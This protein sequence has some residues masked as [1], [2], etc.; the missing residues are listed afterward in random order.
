MSDKPLMP[1][2]INAVLLTEHR[3]G[4]CRAIVVEA[5]ENQRAFLCGAAVVPRGDGAPG[6]WCRF[7]RA[8][9]VEPWPPRPI[10]VIKKPVVT[11]AKATVNRPKPPA[12]RPAEVDTT[13]FILLTDA[14]KTLGRPTATLHTW[15]QTGRIAR[16]KI[17]GRSFFRISDVEQ[18]AANKAKPSITVS[19]GMGA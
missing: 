9:Y 16:I 8:I 14:A 17:A 1:D 7:H 6:S 11:K 15:A 13:K 4:Q 5:T 18:M 19:S 12:A 2:G 10:V 3:E